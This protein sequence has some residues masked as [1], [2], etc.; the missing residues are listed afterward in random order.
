MSAPSPGPD[1]TT[2]FMGRVGHSCATALLATSIATQKQTAKRASFTFFSR[3]ATDP[4]GTLEEP[5]VRGQV[6]PQTD[7]PHIGGPSSS[8]G[9]GAPAGAPAFQ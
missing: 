4:A 2:S 1:G 9:H 5:A 7:P 3:T 6:G 8:S